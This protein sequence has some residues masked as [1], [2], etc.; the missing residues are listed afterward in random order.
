MLTTH[1]TDLTSLARRNKGEY[2][3]ADLEGLFTPPIR[4]RTVAHGSEQM[5]VW[6]PTFRAI[7]GSSALAQARI[8]ALLAYIESV[9]K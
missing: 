7:D 2:P 3:L 6:G 9:Q 4:L 1:P 8:A 5:P